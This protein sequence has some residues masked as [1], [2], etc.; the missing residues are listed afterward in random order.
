MNCGGYR[1]RVLLCHR[2]VG[3]SCDCF[4][5]L[6]QYLAS[7]LDLA[8]SPPP[9]HLHPPE[10]RLSTNGTS[11]GRYSQ[12]SGALHLQQRIGESRWFGF[13]TRKSIEQCHTQV[14]EDERDYMSLTED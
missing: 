3:L 7:F 14:F 10:T 8:Q 13:H 5:Y 12:R 1:Y 6:V 2:P 11:L 9:L 4:P